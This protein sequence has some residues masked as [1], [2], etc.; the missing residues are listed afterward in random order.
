MKLLYVSQ[1]LSLTKLE[2]YSNKSKCEKVSQLAFWRQ[3]VF[4]RHPGFLYHA[5]TDCLNIYEG[6]L[7]PLQSCTDTK[8]IYQSYLCFLALFIK[9]LQL[10]GNLFFLLYDVFQNSFFIIQITIR[11]ETSTIQKINNTPVL[12]NP[13]LFLVVVV[14]FNWITDKY[15]FGVC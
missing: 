4:C 2:S 15:F 3:V 7:T 14:F 11:T 13:V 6:I 10:S 5:R 1:S 12:K 9:F 8:N